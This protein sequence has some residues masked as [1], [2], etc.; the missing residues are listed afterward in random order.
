MHSH[1]Y[2]IGLFFLGYKGGRVLPFNVQKL[3]LIER[4]RILNMASLFVFK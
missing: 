2:A 3:Y 1:I 4:L